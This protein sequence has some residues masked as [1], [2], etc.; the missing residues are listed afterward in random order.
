[1]V[2]F[3]VSRNAD[4]WYKASHAHAFRRREEGSLFTFAIDHLGEALRNHV[5]PLAVYDPMTMSGVQ[6][7]D[8]SEG[9]APEPPRAARWRSFQVPI[10]T[11]L[12]AASRL[13]PH[14]G[15]IS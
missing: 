11:R 3:N 14:N 15:R 12:D 9:H 6:R 2:R 10:C 13:L 1:M 8:L 7:A 4:D 5:D